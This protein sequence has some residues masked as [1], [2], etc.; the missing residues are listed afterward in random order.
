ML[1]VEQTRYKRWQPLGRILTPL[2]DA[3]VSV[4]GA[5][6]AQMCLAWPLIVGSSW[7]NITRPLRYQHRK[8]EE[9]GH[10]TIHVLET[11]ALSASYAR[12][13]LIQSI[14][15]YFG[16][17]AVSKITFRPTYQLNNAPQPT[18]RLEQKTERKYAGAEL[19]KKERSFSDTLNA[20]EETYRAHAKQRA[21]LQ[22]AEGLRRKEVSERSPVHFSKN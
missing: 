2:T 22:G 16:S 3:C 21:L 14:N 4:S 12:D 6:W 20:F 17:A 13:E 11:H 18:E 5:Y 1:K 19:R 10:L 9:E 8:G 7:A 15:S